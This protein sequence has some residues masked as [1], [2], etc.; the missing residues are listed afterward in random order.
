LNI[1]RGVSIYEL[2]LNLPILKSKKGKKKKL[3]KKGK[4][5]IKKKKR[6]YNQFMDKK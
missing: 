5:K 4:R 3:K 6:I 2:E 1:K